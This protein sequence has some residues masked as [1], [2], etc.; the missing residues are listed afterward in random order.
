MEYAVF[1]PSALLNAIREAM[2]ANNQLG[3]NWTELVTII[4]LYE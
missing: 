2:V 1:I 3:I 4:S